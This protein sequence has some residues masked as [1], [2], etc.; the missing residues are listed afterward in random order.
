MGVSFF[1]DKLGFSGELVFNGNYGRV[2]SRPLV[3]DT[4]TNFFKHTD[5]SKFK[6]TLLQKNTAFFGAAFLL[7]LF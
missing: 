6:H 3:T 4:F 7:F 2:T 1:G 5:K